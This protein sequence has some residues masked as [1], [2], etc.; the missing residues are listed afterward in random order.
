M[1]ACTAVG[2][3]SLTPG[4]LPRSSLC[5]C[6]KYRVDGVVQ[7]FLHPP[8]GITAKSLISGTMDTA[9]CLVYSEIFNG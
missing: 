6:W 3:G 4:R 5:T 7:V 8:Y 9:L 1:F 2:Q